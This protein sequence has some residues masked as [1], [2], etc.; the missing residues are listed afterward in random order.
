VLG[1]PA[2]ASLRLF[3]GWTPLAPDAS[4]LELADAAELAGQWINAV[5]V[6]VDRDWTGA[7]PARLTWWSAAPYSLPDAAGRPGETR[8]S[9]HIE[10]MNS[11]NV[12]ATRR[13]ERSFTRSGLHRRAAAAHGA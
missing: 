7:A 3:A 5:Q 9:V 4:S 12:Q 10:L 2:S 6:V 8:R 11:V 1:R 13:P